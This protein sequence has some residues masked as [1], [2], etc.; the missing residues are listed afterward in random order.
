[1]FQ[2]INTQTNE[3]AFVGKSLTE[4]QN[5]AIKKRIFKVERTKY[6]RHVICGYWAIERVK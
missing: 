5:Y 2:L 4:C 6:F 1:M 3:V